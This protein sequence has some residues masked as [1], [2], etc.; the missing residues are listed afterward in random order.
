[1][2]CSDCI[3]VSVRQ[4]L[5][6]L[7]AIAAFA[8]RRIDLAFLS[9]LPKNVVRLVMRACLEKY[10]GTTRTLHE[11][12]FKGFTGRRVNDVERSAGLS[13]KVGRTLYRICFQ[14]RRPDAF[15]SARSS[16]PGLSTLSRSRKTH[17]NEIYF[18]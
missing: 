13:R 15:E 8:Q 5:P 7:L 1:M 10:L 11:G 6:Q 12:K 4:P 3:N 9:A 16:S 17:A 18:G 14:E 2:V